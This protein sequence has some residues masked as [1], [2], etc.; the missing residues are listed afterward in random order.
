MRL[1]IVMVLVMLGM[2]AQAAPA[3]AEVVPFPEAPDPGGATFSNN[4]RRIRALLVHG[5]T[6][7]AGG[8]FTVSQGAVTRSNLAAFDF[9]GN[10]R[11]EFSV[12]VNGPVW[13]LATD[14]VSLFVGGEF[15]RLELNSY[16][17]AVD[18]VS[19]AVRRQFRAHIN[20][21][22][23]DETATGVHALAVAT[24]ASIQ[25]PTVNL[26]VGGNFA[27]VN[28]TMDNRAG[29]AA[30]STDRGSLDAARFT[31]VVEGGYV[32]ALI[33]SGTTVYVGGEFTNIQGRAASLAALTTSG[34]LRSGAFSTG[35][36]PVLDL[37]IDEEGNRLFAAIGG[38]GN[39]VR[40]YVASGG[41]RGSM[42]WRG[43][44]VGGA[45]HWVNGDVQAVHYFAGNVYFGF[46][47]G[48]FE[49]PDP[50]KLAAVDASTGNLEVD[51]EHPG[52]TCGNDSEEQQNNCWLPR[53]DQ[54]AGQGFFGV[55]AIGDFLDPVTN[56]QALLVGG[57]FTQIGGVTRTRRMAIFRAP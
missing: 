26:I 12:S 20:G 13:A 15:T 52:L 45:A 55:W 25:P 4:S 1:W 22:L 31:Q 7:Y 30:L 21:A 39:G 50:F 19:G 16:L 49:E 37:T 51:F 44:R 24:D 10:L 43:P 28:S 42:L 34:T 53:L 5:D 8:R 56:Q 9:N 29:L 18:P 27:Q 3:L 23:D 33:A 6:I 36:S 41:R 11:P 14:G 40:G 48:L 17:A 47:D 46:H 2:S 35:G 54:T 38:I 57:D 32:R